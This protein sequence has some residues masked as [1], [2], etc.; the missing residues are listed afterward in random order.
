MDLLIH[1][2][3]EIPEVRPGDDLVDLIISSSQKESWKWADGDIVVLAQKIVSKSE[4]RFV[5]LNEITPGIK[6]ISYSKYVEKDPRLIEL[7]LRESVKVLRT[8]KGLMIVEHRLGF[9]CANAGIDHSNISTAGTLQDDWVLL[10][11][12]NPDLTASRIRITLEAK[13]GKSIG[14]LIIDS[15]GRTWRKGVVGTTIGLSGIPGI[16]DQRGKKDRNGFELKVTEIAAADELAAGASLLMGQVAE[17]RP[18]V[19]A[20]GFPYKLR[21]SNLSEIIRVESEDLFR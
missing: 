4:N 10:L 18:I 1:A 21:D 14:V 16:I 17:G 9:I 13:L 5:N 15:H 3:E 12:E 6:A 19:I 7:I 11:P 2:L 20:K 8:R